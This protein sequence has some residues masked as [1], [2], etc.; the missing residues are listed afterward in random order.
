MRVSRRPEASE[1]QATRTEDSSKTHRGISCKKF[2]STPVRRACGAFSFGPLARDVETPPR[3]ETC[4]NCLL[5]SAVIRA[6]LRSDI[7]SLRVQT[8]ALRV[9]V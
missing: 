2:G 8:R 9:F 4:A 1:G 6:E 5:A 3:A 7:I